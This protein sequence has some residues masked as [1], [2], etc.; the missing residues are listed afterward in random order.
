MN[1]SIN[2]K[3]MTSVLINLI[4][5]KMLLTFPKELTMTAGNAAWIQSIY[6]T[7]ITL[8]LYIITYKIYPTNKNILTIAQEKGKA[9]LRIIVGIIMSSFL[10]VNMALTM[11]VFPESIRIV[12]LQH[13]PMEFLMILFAVAVVIG[14]YN[15]IESL[16]RISL[17]FLPIV[18]VIMLFFLILVFPYMKSTNIAPVLGLG[19]KAIF[20]KGIP[21][22]SAFND[23]LIMNYLMPLCESKEEAYRG[24]LKAIIISGTVMTLI[25]FCYALVYPYP[26]SSEFLMPMYQLTRII[27]IGDF[28]ARFDAFFEFIWTIMMLL[29]SAIYIF[30]ICNI[31]KDTFLLKYYKPLIMPVMVIVIVMT[32]FSSSIV[33]VLQ[34]HT[35]FSRTFYPVAFLLPLGFGILYRLGN[36]QKK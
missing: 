21:W 34:A 27:T 20:L 24:G 31:W 22:I 1:I 9:P 7:A 8:I 23:I 32:F 16:S 36:R 35:H 11:R 6:I 28:L 2:K 17:L 15:G 10:L 14:A 29:Y 33:D 4:C 30:V 18:G 12:L 3:E 13:T 26:V 25:Q 19:P 5:V